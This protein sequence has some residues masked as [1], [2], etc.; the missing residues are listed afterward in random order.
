MKCGNKVILFPRAEAIIASLEREAAKRPALPIFAFRVE[1]P[2][3]TR[4]CLIC[5]ICASTVE[6][7]TRAVR[8]ERATWARSCD[9]CG[10]RNE[11]AAKPKAGAR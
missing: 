4:H 3:R 5:Q 6:E 1:E 2:E 11:E 10:A 9:W 7:P 8:L